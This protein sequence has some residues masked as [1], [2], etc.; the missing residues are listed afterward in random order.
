MSRIPL[1]QAELVSRFERIAEMSAR[2]LTLV[3][4]AA[5]LGMS[6]GTLMNLRSAARRAG[7]VIS[8]ARATNRGMAK[9]SGLLALDAS[10]D[11]PA[12]ERCGLHG[13]HG[14][15]RVVDF[16]FRREERV[17]PASFASDEEAQAA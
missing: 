16:M 7:Y 17:E 14:C 12:C 5:Q 13:D 11:G 9:S 10:C 1:T 2:G 8:D 6:A 3:E 15:V 4:Q